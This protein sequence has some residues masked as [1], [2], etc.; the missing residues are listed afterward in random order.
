MSEKRFKSLFL[1]SEQV[2]AANYITELLMQ[3]YAKAKKIGVPNYPFWRKEYQERNNSEV[4][5]DLADRYGKEIISVTRL[6][7]V[8]SPVV[9]V[10]YITTSW[11]YTLFYLKKVQQQEVIFELYKKQVKRLD[12][13]AA[14]MPQPEETDEDRPVPPVKFTGLSIG[15]KKTKIG[16]L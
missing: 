7:K 10:D 4:I 14:N 11:P 8:F 15:N 3:K 13:P 16:M 9:L 6:L 5:Q 2:D 12:G 1:P